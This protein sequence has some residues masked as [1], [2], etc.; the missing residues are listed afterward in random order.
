[1]GSG[2]WY[3]GLLHPFRDLRICQRSPSRERKAELPDGMRSGF[4][5]VSEGEA[6]KLRLLF[7]K[8]VD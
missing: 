1:M 5:S 3:T 7:P 6:P 2:S 8:T 4:F